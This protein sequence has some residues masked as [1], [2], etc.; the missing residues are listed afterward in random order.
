MVVSR[1]IMLEYGLQ[2]RIKGGGIESY[3]DVLES[4]DAEHIGD[5]LIGILLGTPEVFKCQALT[6][7]FLPSPTVKGF[8]VGTAPFAFG[9][10]RT[11]TGFVNEVIVKQ[12][13]GRQCHNKRIASGGESTVSELLHVNA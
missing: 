1:S 7:H 12:L 9:D 10:E 5:L 6:Q 13:D 4:H 11:C 3:T 2:I 8:T